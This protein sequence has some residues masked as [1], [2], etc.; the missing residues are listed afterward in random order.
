[1]R[2]A[3]FTH[4]YH[5]CLG[6]AEKY[7]REMV[8]RFVSRGDHVDVFTSDADDLWYFVRRD[9]RRLDGP[10]D[11]CIDG[12]RVR[13]FPVRHYPAQRYVRRLV[14]YVPHWPTQCRVASY[15]PIIPS[16]DRVRGAYDAVFGVGFPYTG[17]SY[18]AWKT[19]RAASAAL[20]LTPFLHLA[21]P[22]DKVNKTYTKPHQIELLRKAD[23]VVVQTNLEADAVRAWGIDPGR[24]LRLG[25]G[26]DHEAV[27]GGDRQA[28]RRSLKLD[29]AATVVGQMGTCDPNKGTTDLVRALGRLNESRGDRPI[30]LLLGGNSSP[31]FEA[32][33]AELPAGTSRWLHRL[34]P[35]RGKAIAD[36]Y[37]AIDVFAMPSRTDSFGIVYLEAW[38]NG[39][40]VI[41]ANAGGVAEVISHDRNGLLVEFGDVERLGA[42]IGRLIGDTT[43][44][45]QLGVAG[46][47]HVSRGFSWDDRFATLSS[48]TDDLAASRHDEGRRFATSA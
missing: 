34:G 16:L 10:A 8:K 37:A 32:F 6:G 13:R 42:S 5:P 2:I 12:A 18:A 19:A 3:W 38:A 1:M 17:F 35:L 41:G 24:V 45:R 30:P 21:T 11:E 47:A 39:L 9:R 27:T 25:M 31:E 29:D 46:R 22:G 43:F 28:L 33:I 48:L 4:R 26:V 40:P 7:G 36:F 15:L 44:A 14:S 23:S 20:I